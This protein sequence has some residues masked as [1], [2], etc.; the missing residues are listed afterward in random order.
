MKTVLLFFFCHLTIIQAWAQNAHLQVVAEQDL[1]IFVDGIYR[2]RTTAEVGGLVVEDLTP[3][4]HNVKMVKEGSEPFKGQVNLTAGQVFTYKPGNPFNPEIII[5]QSG[6]EAIAERGTGS[7]LI[8]SFPVS[9]QIRIAQLDMVSDKTRYEWKAD[10]IPTGTYEALFYAENGSMSG[11]LEIKEDSITH[12]HV[13]VAD[14]ILEVAYTE[15]QNKP[16]DYQT[17]NSQRSRSTFDSL[18]FGYRLLRAYDLEFEYLNDTFFVVP[19]LQLAIINVKDRQDEGRYVDNNGAYFI[20]LKDGRTYRFG[21]KILEV[22]YDE[23][24]SSLITL[25]KNLFGFEVGVQHP[26]IN[27]FVVDTEIQQ[28]W[29]KATFEEQL[30]KH[31]KDWV[32][33][34]QFKFQSVTQS[35]PGRTNQMS[36]IV[37][38]KY[39]FVDGYILLFESSQISANQRISPAGD[40]TIFQK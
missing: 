2:G 31:E 40:L 34:E 10:K 18:T 3:G 27:G 16:G 21:Q 25:V 15:S 32:K 36:S 9:I 28:G 5:T 14:S 19:E 12:I 23:K 1:M 13:N 7:L 29:N 37:Y 38:G 35:Q 26:L 4:V 17:I 30:S 6:A 39:A 20:Q 22:Y 8:Q 33:G 11:I 24:S